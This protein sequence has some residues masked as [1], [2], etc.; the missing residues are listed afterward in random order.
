MLHCNPI[1]CGLW[2]NE[3]L[4]MVG[5]NVIDKSFEISKLESSASTYASTTDNR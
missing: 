4:R 5:S 2:R 1:P 3:S